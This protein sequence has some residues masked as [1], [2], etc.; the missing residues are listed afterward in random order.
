[1]LRFALL[2]LTCAI[3]LAGCL[4]GSGRRKTAAMTAADSA[5]VKFAQTVPVDTLTQVWTAS[6]PAQTP[7]ALPTS[8]TWLPK[9]DAS[10]DSTLAPAER[11]R[12]AVIETKQG[13]VQF[14]T[15]SGRADGRAEVP[16]GA[17][18]YPYLAG[19]R[20]DTLVV[21]SRGASAFDF[22]AGGAWARRISTSETGRNGLATDSLLAIRTGGG[23][24]EAPRL[25]LL[26]ES[27]RVT[28][29]RDLPGAT[30]R[31]L[32]Y[33]RAWGD[34]VL[35]LSGYRPVIDVLE[36]GDPARAPLDSLALHGFD[37]PQLV[38]SYQFML[39]EVDQP[40][41]LTSSAVPL[42]DRLIVINLRAEQVRFDLYDRAGRLRQVLVTP[43]A[44]APLNAYPADLAARRAADGSVE[45]A[46]LMQRPGGFM[47]D[48][49][50]EVVL[51]RWLPDARQEIAPQAAR[52]KER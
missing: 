43:H 18:A 38:R 3:L 24:G 21:F 42:G 31:S 19:V 17:S 14:F 22:W 34:S 36:P 13:A 20:G 50:A 30:W 11:M 23:E 52:T 40:P 7:F 4:P 5:S 44:E 2:A 47:R 26:S 1:M 49:D 28:V 33:L 6:A 25:I 15:A 48:A 35:A 8:L 27:G 29:Q 10:P 16:G 9:D 32:G 37:S 12:L 51:F 45:I 39:G 46:T 41:L